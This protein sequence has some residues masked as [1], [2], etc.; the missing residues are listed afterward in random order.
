MRGSSE[1]W[2]QLP[3]T[4]ATESGTSDSHL[5]LIVSD[6]YLLG[7]LIMGDQTISKPLRDLIDAHADISTIRNDLLQS[8]STLGPAL[9]DFWTKNKKEQRRVN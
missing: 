9:V 2:L 5:R 6:K 3:N 7:A 1:S 8:G 4:I